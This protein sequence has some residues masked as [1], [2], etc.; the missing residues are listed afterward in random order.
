MVCKNVLLQSSPTFKGMIRQK[1]KKH[2]LI[3]LTPNVT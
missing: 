3:P 2:I 1:K